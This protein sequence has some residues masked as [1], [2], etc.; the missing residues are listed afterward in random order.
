MVKTTKLYICSQFWW[1]W[2]S[3]KVTFV[4]EIRKTLVFIFSQIFVSIWMEFSM[5]TQPV[6]LLKLIL[7]LFYTSNIQGRVL[8]RY[9][10]MN[11]TFNINMFQDTCEPI[12]FKVGVMLNSTKLCSL[13]QVWKTVMFTLCHRIMGKLEFMQSF[14]CKL[15]E[16]TQMFMIVDFV[17][18]ITV[19]KSFKYG[20]YGSFRA[21]FLL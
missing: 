4:W 8:C 1:P 6:G 20:E 7:N 13:I 12:C 14:S 3:F 21:L 16:A 2:P 5:L 17:R 10:F 19:K 9:D 15:R 11:Y 18:K